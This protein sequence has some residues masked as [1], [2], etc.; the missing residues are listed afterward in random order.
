MKLHFSLQNP[1]KQDQLFKKPE[2]NLK[3]S[4]FIK[5]STVIKQEKITQILEENQTRN[6]TKT[7]KKAQ[8][9]LYYTSDQEDED[10]FMPK[11]FLVKQEN[12]T[13][14]PLKDVSFKQRFNIDCDFCENVSICI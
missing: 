5:P 2:I 3:S 14:K 11:P 10:E 9:P 4:N 1:Q 8:N 6:L 13:P 12:V 7:T